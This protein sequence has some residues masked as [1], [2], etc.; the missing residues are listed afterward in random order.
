MDRHG[1]DRWLGYVWRVDS[2]TY[3]HTHTHTVQMIYTES[4]WT[5]RDD[6]GYYGNSIGVGDCCRDKAHSCTLMAVVWL[7]I[8]DFLT[9]SLIDNPMINDRVMTNIN[10]ECKM[11]AL[12]SC[13]D[14]VLFQY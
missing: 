11:V 10:L 12:L 4:V 2:A 6:K 14:N 1:L 8:I 9:K 7:L 5:R 13:A 3:T